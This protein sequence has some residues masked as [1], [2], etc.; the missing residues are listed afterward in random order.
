M[1]PTATQRGGWI[2]LHVEGEPYA[3]S[4]QYGELV[5]TEL[6]WNPFNRGLAF[7][8]SYKVYGQGR[9]DLE[10]SVA[11]NASSPTNR[12]HA[13]DGC[14]GYQLP[15]I[16]G[17]FLLHQ[18]RLRLGNA[19]FAKKMAAIHDQHNGKPKRSADILKAFGEKNGPFIR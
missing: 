11:I 6:A 4:R 5:A 1:I 3:R 14:G 19:V 17:T 13:C 12:P 2:V 9:F 8:E 18:L 7:W 15:R 10:A 16:K